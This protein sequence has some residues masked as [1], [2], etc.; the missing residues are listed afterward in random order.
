MLNHLGFERIRQKGSHIYFRHSDGRA[1]VVPFHKGEDL[2]KGLL[3]AILKD[4][5]LSW[6]EFIAAR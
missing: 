5:E 4:I 3:G 1:T 6:E 2:G